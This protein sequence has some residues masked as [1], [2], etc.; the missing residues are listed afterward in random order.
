MQIVG[1]VNLKFSIL[2]P[3][4]NV[5]RYLE[6]CLKSVV[7]QTFC[8][9]EVIIVD[10][11][12]TDNSSYICDSFAEKY[13]EKIHVIHKENQGLISARRIAIDKAQGEFCVFVD[14]DDFVECNLL[15]IVNSYLLKDDNIDMVIYSFNYYCDSVKTES[16]R[17]VADD[18]EIWSGD[19]KIRIYELL[20]TGDSIDALWI[21]AIK[22]EILK[23]DPIDYKKYF[24]KNMSE[25]T[26]QSIYPI[27]YA[28]KIIYAD[29]PLYNYRYNTVSISRN[30]SPEGI[31][32]KDSSHVFEEMFF[33]LPDWKLNTEEFKQKIYARW[34]SD[35]MY[36]FVKSCENAAT[37]KEMDSILEFNWLS[38][39][40][41]SGL[42]AFDVYVNQQ[43]K[44]LY[45]YWFY[46]KFRKIK[47]IFFKRK[48]YKKIVSLKRKL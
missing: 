12:S 35:V 43:Y 46:N 7:N 15:E 24:S 44:N 18:S 33:V 19:N 2:I 38:M 17:F 20:A 48:I 23:R 4:Y 13:P 37:N 8:D 27:T 30:F 21:K 36:I 47:V 40:P 6:Q 28:K 16:N 5:E 39:L 42:K 1:G 3:V 31:V 9:Y 11:G 32:K 34:F 29:V 22:T 41:S 10:D 45:Y 14:S 25:D 26:L